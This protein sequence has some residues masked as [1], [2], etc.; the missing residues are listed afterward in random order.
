MAQFLY[1]AALAAHLT[2]TEIFAASLI[3]MVAIATV[4]WLIGRLA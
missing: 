2:N 4:T 3:T 1:N